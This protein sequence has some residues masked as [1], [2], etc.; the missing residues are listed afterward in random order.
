MLLR[1]LDPETDT[2]FAAVVRTAAGKSELRVYERR[3]G[4][5]GYLL[6]HV[7]QQGDRFHNL[8]LEDVDGDGQEEMIATWAG[9]HLEVLDVIARGQ[10]GTYRSLFQN[11]GQ[12][13]ETHYGPEGALEFWIT[14]RT[15]KER[16]GQAPAYDTAIYRWD[17]KRFSEAPKRQP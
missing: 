17:G 16:P 11:A 14:S 1:A 12:E 15:Y 10:D 7:E 3:A 2:R 8:V 4:P 6:A 5:G 9:G 13:I